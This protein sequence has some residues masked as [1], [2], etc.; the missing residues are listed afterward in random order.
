MSKIVVGIN[1]LKTWCQN[2]GEYGQQ[3]LQEWTGIDEANN[4]IDMR[5]VSYA[6]T[7][8]VQWKCKEGHE[9]VAEIHNRVPRGT[10][11]HGT[12]CPYC[13][14]KKVSDKNSLI[15]WCK[16]NGEYGLQLLQ[17]WTGL[18]ENDNPIEINEISYASNKKV[19]WKCNK[20][21]VWIATVLHRTYGRRCPYCA[22]KKVSEKNSLKTW[23]E[24]NG[25]LGKSIM[26]EWV[27]LDKSYNAVKMH[28]VPYGSHKKVQWKCSKGH[29]WVAQ[30]LSRTSCKSGCPYCNSY[31]TSFPEQFIFHSLKQIYK[32]AITRGKYQGYEYDITIPKLRLCIEYSGINW[33][34]G[35]LDRDEEKSNLCKKYGVKFLQIYAHSG[36]I[37]DAEGQEFYATYSREQIIYK[38]SSRKD[39]HIKQLQEIVKFILKQYDPEHSI[40]EIDFDIAE[41]EANKIMQGIEEMEESSNE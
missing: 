39:I 14:S 33:H 29:E 31:S 5:K 38:V 32:D 37:K 13:Y 1:D 16:Q 15:K 3:L 18:D 11:L 6:S 12:R 25:E 40:N 22:G 8:K 35:K 2:N 21:H 24:Q 17:E 23:C 27:G 30:I 20:G 7:Q 41:L 28:E 19:Q 36:Q 34:I 10:R 9:W 26:K 4:T